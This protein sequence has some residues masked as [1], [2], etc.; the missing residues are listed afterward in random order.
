[1]LRSYHYTV[2]SCLR[3]QIRLFCGLPFIG[4]ALAL[5]L[6]ALLHAYDSFEFI[7]DQQGY[8]VAERFA[9]IESHWV[10][11]LGY[12]GILASLSL[13][14]RFWDL[15]ALRA[16]L[17]PIY[18]ANAPHACFEKHKARRPLPVFQ[19]PLFLFNCVLQ[20]CAMTLS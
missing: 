7:W 8:G 5:I 17:Y 1:M 6:S 16:V 3:L 20:L 13:Q 18:I 4:P 10:Y 15:F 11:F 9:L 12:G 19:L 14:L 2:P